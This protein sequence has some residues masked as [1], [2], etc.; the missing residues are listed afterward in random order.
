MICV[1][2]SE[3]VSQ[4][5]ELS[6]FLDKEIDFR[7]KQSSKCLGSVTKDYTKWLGEDYRSRLKALVGKTMGRRR[8]LLTA[9]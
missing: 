4:A 2:N 9:S 1:D 5:L 3:S 7:I 6:D 8:L